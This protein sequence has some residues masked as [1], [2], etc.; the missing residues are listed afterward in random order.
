VDTTDYGEGADGT[1]IGQENSTGFW[2]TNDDGESGTWISAD[3]QVTGEWSFD[4]DSPTTGTW[5]YSDNSYCG[6]WATDS[7]DD[8]VKYDTTPNDDDE[9]DETDYGEGSDGTWR[10]NSTESNGYWFHNSD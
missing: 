2:F 1:W 6:T 10:G 3:G 7:S 9:D 4:E 5:C 8:T